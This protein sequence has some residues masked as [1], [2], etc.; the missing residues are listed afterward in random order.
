MKKSLSIFV[1]FTFIFNLSAFGQFTFTN[2]GNNVGIGTSTP[3]AKLEIVHSGVALKF[4]RPGY[5]TYSILQSAS[6]GLS[7]FNVGNNSIAMYFANNGNIGLGTTSPTARMHIEHSGVALKFSR[8][9]YATFS[10]QQS[11]SN[12]LSI[13]NESTNT[14]A[15]YFSGFGNSNSTKVFGTLIVGEVTTPGNYSIYAEKGILTEKVRVAL[16]NSS[17]WADYVFKKDYKLM[18]LK[19]LEAYIQANQHLPNIPA[20]EQV[21]KEGIDLAEMNIK[22][23][24]KVEELTLHLIEQQKQ[25]E[26]LKEENALI[27]KN[28]K[29]D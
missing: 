4:S 1:L 3:T 23:L 5:T 29:K 15:M 16:K 19:E 6:N 14:Q 8:T 20:A 13:F 28:L 24:E 10:I 2:T 21:K 12:G 7:I 25:I 11:P 27:I 18:P 17:D 9:G 26:A 22:L